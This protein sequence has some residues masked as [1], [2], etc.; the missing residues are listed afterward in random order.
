MDIEYNA[1]QYK[2]QGNLAYKNQD[3]KK[4]INLYSSAIR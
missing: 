1:N 3:Y 2:Q 4:A